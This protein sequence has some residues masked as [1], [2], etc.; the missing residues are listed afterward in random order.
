M[1]N[2]KKDE[3]VLG[4]KPGCYLGLKLGKTEG[5]GGDVI[6][7]GELANSYDEARNKVSF[8]RYLTFDKKNYSIIDVH[9]EGGDFEGI[10]P[11]NFL[12]GQ[13]LMWNFGGDQKTNELLDAL[14][15]Q[16]D[17]VKHQEYVEAIKQ[18]K[19]E[20]KK[21]REMELE[22]RKAKGL[23]PTRWER[24]E[25]GFSRAGELAKEGVALHLY[26]Y[27]APWV[28]KRWD[29]VGG[30]NDADDAGV[31]NGIFTTLPIGIAAG[32]VYLL[33]TKSV[34]GDD[35]L[36]RTVVTNPD[37]I[38]VATSLFGIA[39]VSLVSKGIESGIRKL[40]DSYEYWKGQ[41]ERIKKLE[42]VRQAFCPADSEE[43]YKAG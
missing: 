22:E 40:I 2:D 38:I 26:G 37:P 41:K 4:T 27:I 33:N 28:Y 43:Y 25:S 36:M 3:I 20:K 17:P 15:H 35:N 8:G 6:V 23:V 31:V 12:L 7:F 29:P 9:K 34:I 13:E 32:V 16:Y 10:A 24:F 11:E 39:G 14:G 42:R 30:V 1:S 21:R 18:M 19:K 5:Y